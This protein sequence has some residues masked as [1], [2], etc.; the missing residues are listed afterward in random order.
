MMLQNTSPPGDVSKLKLYSTS[1]QHPQRWTIAS[2]LL[3]KSKWIFKKERVKSQWFASY[4]QM[5]Q[6]NYNLTP[7]IEKPSCDQLIK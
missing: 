6:E 7:F 1:R 3:M 4:L 5:I 2:D